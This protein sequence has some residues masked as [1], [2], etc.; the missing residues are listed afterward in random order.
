M[1]E[2]RRQELRRRASAA[3]ALAVGAKTEAE[4]RYWRK[5]SDV[6]EEKL[7]GEPQ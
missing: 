7:G 6:Y 3:N 2:E 4:R 1:N 5:V